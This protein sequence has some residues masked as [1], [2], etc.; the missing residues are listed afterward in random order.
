MKRL[1]V[2][3]AVIPLLLSCDLNG[4][5]DEML[6]VSPTIKGFSFSTQ[7]GTDL[8]DADAT[9]ALTAVIVAKSKFEGKKGDKV[10]CQVQL[11]GDKYGGDPDKLEIYYFLKG[12]LT[13]A[14][15]SSVEISI[16]GQFSA[17]NGTWKL[18][19][20]DDGDKITL[21]NGSKVVNLKFWHETD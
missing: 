3:L 16:K 5:I 7:T 1:L 8:G 2:F 17:L 13:Y 18:T 6:K 12:T 10:D 9:K 20:E 11:M 14:S 19:R 21:E 4:K 15:E